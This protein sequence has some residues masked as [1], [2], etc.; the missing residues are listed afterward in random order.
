MTVGVTTFRRPKLLR[1][2]IRSVLSQGYRN[3]EIFVIDDCSLDNTEEVARSFTD[4]RMTYIRNDVNQGAVVGRNLALAKAG[5]RYIAFLDDDDSW[6]QGKLERQVALAE[7][8]ASDCAVIY[9][10][11]VVS[12]E[13]REVLGEQRPTMRGSIRDAIASGSLSTIPSSHLFRTELLRKI[14]GYD[15]S[16]PSHN[17]HDI[18]MEMARSD[19]KADYV[20]APLVRI[21]SQAGYHMSTD[22]VLRWRATHA[23]FE[24]WR[25]T[26][27]SWMGPRRAEDYEARYFA[28]VIGSAARVEIRQGRAMS[29]IRL[30]ARLF[31]RYPVRPPVYAI[32][33]RMIVGGV[34]D[35]SRF[36]PSVATL[37]RTLGK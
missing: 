9:C 22:A 32:S 21:G 20:D 27:R 34:L 6:E 8:D 30:F 15:T 28:L 37:K 16:L 14:G 10:G 25:P 7:G 33:A 4:S 19:Y 24:K 36:L 13:H 26:F 31:L 29:A 3:L 23:F 2:A 11:G 1:L 12:S 35:G 18:W 17:E 5:G